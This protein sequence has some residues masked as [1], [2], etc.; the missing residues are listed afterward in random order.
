MSTNTYNDSSILFVFYVSIV[1]PNKF[2]MFPDD[3]KLAFF[4][5]RQGCLKES[6]FFAVKQLSMNEVDQQGKFAWREHNTYAP[7]YEQ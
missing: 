1:K 5:I 4:K 6:A 3:R 7:W 2:F